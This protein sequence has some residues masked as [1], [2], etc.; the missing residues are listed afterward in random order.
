VAGLEIFLVSLIL[1][2]QSLN[3]KPYCFMTCC[4]DVA[5]GIELQGYLST[6]H[7]LHV[8][9]GDLFEAMVQGLPLQASLFTQPCRDNTLYLLALVDE[10]VMRDAFRILPQFLPSSDAFADETMKVNLSGKN[11]LATKRA[12]RSKHLQGM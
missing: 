6:F 12:G 4:I 2:A 3:P 8:L 5:M 9:L 1:H 10:L 7:T 11:C